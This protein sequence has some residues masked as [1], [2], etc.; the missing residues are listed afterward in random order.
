MK[1]QAFPG[2]AVLM[3]WDTEHLSCISPARSQQVTR[4]G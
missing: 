4:F 3:T 1:S 2:L